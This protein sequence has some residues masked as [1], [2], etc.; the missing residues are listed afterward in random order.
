MTDRGNGREGLTLRRIGVCASVWLFLVA[1]GCATIVSKSDYVVNLN[2]DPSE[3]KVTVIDEQNRDVF[4][5]VTPTMAVLPSGDGYFSKS[6]YRVIFEKEGYSDTMFVLGA[7][8]D[9]WYIGNIL[10]GGLIG[11]FVVDPITG[12]MF[13]LPERV[14]V[15]LHKEKPAT[16]DL[17]KDVK[18]RIERDLPAED[19]LALVGSEP[20][21]KAIDGRTEYWQWID[22]NGAVLSIRVR[23]G[24]VKGRWLEFVGS[25]PSVD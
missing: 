17:A 18:D 22:Q 12:A 24:K 8:A 19:V 5:G 7:T 21:S 20:T 23:D 6:H 15:D 11:F 13:Q 16:F 25:S 14:D 1:S 4:R 2:S 3:A 10:F 9:D